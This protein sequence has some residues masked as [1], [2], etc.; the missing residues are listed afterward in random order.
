MKMIKRKTEEYEN[1]YTRKH[2]QRECV[3]MGID[4]V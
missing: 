4:K 1:K 2:K 3:S